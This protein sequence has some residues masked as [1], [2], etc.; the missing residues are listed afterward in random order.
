MLQ[1]FEQLTLLSLENIDVMLGI[2]H[3]IQQDIIILILYSFVNF[4]FVFM[5]MQKNSAGTLIGAKYDTHQV[6]KFIETHH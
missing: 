4:A 6:M 2:I 1:K 5:H 3:L